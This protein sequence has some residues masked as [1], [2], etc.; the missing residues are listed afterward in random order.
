[1]NLHIFNRDPKGKVGGSKT[2]PKIKFDMNNSTESKLAQVVEGGSVEDAIKNTYGVSSEVIA[3]NLMALGAA[4]IV[5]KRPVHE[6]VELIIES[7]NE[8][9]PADYFEAQLYTKAV[10]LYDQGMNY[11][12][13]ASTSKLIDHIEKYQ[14]WAVKLLRLH[15]ETIETLTR[16][17]RK[18]EQKFVVQHVNVSDGGQAVV[19][20]SMDR[21]GGC[22]EKTGEVPHVFRV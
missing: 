20:G 11:L 21:I 19:S 16:Y 5:G 17:R 12:S 9:E 13:C 15:N 14:K 4:T 3:G 8:F 18:G 22:H 6:K 1:M 10:A 7:L 2:K